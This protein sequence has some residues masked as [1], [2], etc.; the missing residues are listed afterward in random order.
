MNIKK[1]VYT[2]GNYVGERVFLSSTDKNVN[3]PAFLKGI[4]V[5]LAFQKFTLCLIIFT[6]DLHWRNVRRIFTVDEK[7]R[8]GK[9]AFSFSL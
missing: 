2:F 9:T 7:R 3:G 8:K 6:K 4:Q 1:P 5:F